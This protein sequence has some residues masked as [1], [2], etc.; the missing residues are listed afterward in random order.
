M[1]DSDDDDTMIH[2]PIDQFFEWTSGTRNSCLVV[3]YS[4][5][6]VAAAA[7]EATGS[8]LVLPACV[9]VCACMCE[10][11]CVLIQ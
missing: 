5:V 6:V 10:R 4:V 11:V 9:C 8:D 2:E 3:E 1:E 7:V